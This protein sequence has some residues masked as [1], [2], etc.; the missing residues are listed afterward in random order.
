M[1]ISYILKSYIGLTLLINTNN[2]FMCSQNNIRDTKVI[3]KLINTNN[4]SQTNIKAITFM[5][6]MFE[7]LLVVVKSWC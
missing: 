2:P 5:C 1:F 7:M 6:E 4:F 3:D